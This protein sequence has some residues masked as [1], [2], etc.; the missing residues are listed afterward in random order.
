[1]SRGR[2]KKGSISLPC[3]RYSSPSI[4]ALPSSSFFCYLARKLLNGLA[5]L[6]KK[7]LRGLFFFCVARSSYGSLS[8]LTC[9]TVGLIIA[10]Y[11]QSRLVRPIFINPRGKIDYQSF[12]RTGDADF[13]M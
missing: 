8:M 7:L 4:L 1:M 2:D 13:R 6:G 3:S 5:L 10:R 12:A 11:L 9:L